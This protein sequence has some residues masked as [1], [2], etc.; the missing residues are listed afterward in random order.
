MSNEQRNERNAN[1]TNPNTTGAQ[2]MASEPVISVRDLTVSFASEAGTVHAVRGMNF[3][4]YPGKTL[5]IVGESGSGKSV[6][7][8][9][10]MGLLDKNA[11][12]KGSITYHGEELLNKSDFEMSEIRGKGI[13]MVF[14]DPLS[15]LTP[16]F[17]IGDQIKEALV[18]HN[19]KMTEQQIHDRSIE[20]M[21]LVGIPDPEGRLKS[22]PHEFS[23]GM[24]QRVMI[25]MAIANDPDVII[26]DEPTT[27]LDVTIQAQVLEVLRK[28][29]RE[30]GAAV[31]FITHDLGVIAGVADDIVVMYAGRPVEKADV[32]SIFDHPAMPYTMGLLGA[33]PRSDRERNSRLVPI[34]GSPMNLVNMPKG[35]PFAPRCPL[36][37]DICHTTEPAMEPVPDRPGQFVACHRTQEIVSKGLTFHDVYTVAEAAKSKFAG[38]PRDER[39]MVLDVK[40]MRKTFPLTAG[41]FLRRKIGEVKA[42]DDVTL[43]VREGETVALVGE[44]GSGKSTTLMEI[45]AFKQPQD[46]E[47][48]MFGTKLE[49]K[50]PREKRRELRS[51]VQYVFQDPMS[52]LDPR[53]PIYDILAEPMKVQHYSKEQIRERIGELMRLVELNPDQ[54]D[55]F[56]TQFSG[57]QRQR[58]AIARALSVNPQLVLLDEPVSALD[59]SIQAG[60]INLLE[61]LQNK[62]GVAY[63]FVAHN[64][65]VVR[66][67]SSRVA[68]MY[69]GRIVESGDTEDVFEHPLHPYTQALISAVP[70]PDPK[71]ERTRQRIVL[72]GEVP[73]PTETFEG[74]PFM[75]RCPLMPKLSAEQQARC[76]GERPALRPY[77]TSRP[78]GHQ[79]ACHFA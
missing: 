56:P 32:D 8:M 38:V 17:S 11:S 68:V 10:I 70:V 71:A 14:Q 28:A 4:L 75:G 25:A 57:G 79:V 18:T 45:M 44:S 62:L 55:R 15:A 49:H 63:L 6:T 35:C 74:C 21:N 31:I 16:V 19:P 33:V 58:I 12:V 66:H 34:P 36:A 53:L 1:T 5:G 39:K 47:I 40:H 9:A 30:T 20:L 67:I 24:R 22:F 2:G 41:G 77:D 73:S 26:A 48:E 13:A 37:T 59:V 29:Q 64:L 52:S 60:V 50:M 76:R 72:E 27:A 46:G 43:D 78:S 51:S 69:L 23:G 42:V 54:V 3:D 61:D 65:S 7:S